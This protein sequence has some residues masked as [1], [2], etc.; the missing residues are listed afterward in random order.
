MNKGELIKELVIAIPSHLFRI[1]YRIDKE[2]YVLIKNIVK[3]SGKLPLPRNVSVNKVVALM[4]WGVIFPIHLEGGKGL[5]V[6]IDIIEQFH[7]SE[8]KELQQI[9]DRNSEWIQLTHGLIYYHGVMNT[10][11]LVDRVSDLMKQEIDFLDFL[12]VFSS[13]SDYYKQTA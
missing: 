12:H 2:R 10:S 9:I 5:T 1:L 4:A 3:H 6:P 13:V 8:G 11:L 7:A